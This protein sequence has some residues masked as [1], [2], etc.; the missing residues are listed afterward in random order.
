MYI[1]HEMVSLVRILLVLFSSEFSPHSLPWHGTLNLHHME[2]YVHIIMRLLCVT[3]EIHFIPFP[4]PFPSSP[5]S[6]HKS[7]RFISEIEFMF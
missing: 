6:L 5:P 7:A 1:T 4:P 2:N 3:K